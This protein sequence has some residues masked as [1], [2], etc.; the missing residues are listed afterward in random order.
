MKSILCLLMIAGAAA[1]APAA[2]DDSRLAEARHRAETGMVDL[3]SGRIPEAETAFRESARL[4]ETGLEGADPSELAVVLN[5]LAAT[6]TLRGESAR[7]IPVL[8][9]AL[10]LLDPRHAAT[11]AITTNLA[12]ALIDEGEFTQAAPLVERAVEAGREQRSAQQQACAL[13]L[14]AQIDLHQQHPERAL[15][16]TDMAIEF[17]SQAQPGLMN[18]IRWIRAQALAAA[19][20]KAAAAEEALR[21]LRLPPGEWSPTEHKVLKRFYET[22]TNRRNRKRTDI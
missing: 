1:V 5:N 6:L 21:L 19:G 3:N 14:Q 8:R 22:M 7:A 20:R 4:L 10:H 11:L 12:R 17:A 2:N 9:R 18:R 16:H 15:T 13:G